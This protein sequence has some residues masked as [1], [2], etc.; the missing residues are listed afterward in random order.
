VG[1]MRSERMERAGVEIEG[2]WRRRGE[3]GRDGRRKKELPAWVD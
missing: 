2:V 1:G 3:R